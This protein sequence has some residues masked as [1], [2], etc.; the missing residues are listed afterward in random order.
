MG[1]PA[2][3][4]GEAI[5]NEAGVPTFKYP[6]RA[7]NAFELMWQ[8]SENLRALYET[9][10]LSADGAAGAQD[11]AAEIISGA[12]KGGRTLLTEVESKQVLAAYGIPTVETHVAGSEDDAVARAEKLGYPV[13]LKLYS[14]TVTHKSD[15]GGVQLNLLNADDVRRAWRSIHEAVSKKAGAGHFLGVTVQP[16]VRRE[17]YELILGS[18]T[19][20]QFGPVLLF[21]SGG[22][23]VEVYK[24]RALGLPPLNATL[25]RRLMEQTRIHSALAGVRGRAPV[26]AHALSSLLVRFSQLVA[27][28][29]WISEIDINPLLAS[30]EQLIALDARVVLH[31]LDLPESR[32]PKLAIRPHPTRYVQRCRIKDDVEVTIRPIRPEDEGLMTAFHRSLSERTVY[33][34]YFAPLKLDQR[35]THERLSRICFIDYDR[36]MALVV[37]RANPQGRGEILGVGRLSKLHGSNEAEFALVVSDDW[38]RR[39][40]GARLL[41]AL[42]QVGRDEQLD[43]IA[44]TILADNHAMQHLASKVGFDVQFDSNSHEYRAELKL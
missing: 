41:S 8:Y 39:G 6:D 27:E 33:L 7:A 44:A 16:M 21:G 31:P 40:L 9:P 5:L 18:S 12:R 36:E 20:P 19:D 13:V 24:D 17:G 14:E 23:F 29:P 1:G 26:D 4:A 3:Q 22:E 37:E 35:I 42:V 38:Q 32:L 11:V 25:A 30:S 34:R 10:A 28:Q 15:V 43:C 2:V